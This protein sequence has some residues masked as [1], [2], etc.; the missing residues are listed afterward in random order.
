M[1]SLPF[2][3]SMMGQVHNEDEL[4]PEAQ[5]DDITPNEAFDPLRRFD[6]WLAGDG[7]PGLAQVVKTSETCATTR[8]NGFGHT[9]RHKPPIR[10]FAGCSSRPNHARSTEHTQQPRKT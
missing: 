8:Q 6:D 4:N 1:M 2:P 10:G 7:E 5:M 3:G 9:E